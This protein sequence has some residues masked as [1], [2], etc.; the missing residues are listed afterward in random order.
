MAETIVIIPTYNEREN[1][2]SLVLE[3]FRHAPYVNVL[4]VDD[5]SPDGTGVIAD[6]MAKE[7]S[8]VLVMHRAVRKERSADGLREALKDQGV[9][10]VME[11]DADFTHKPSYIPDFLREIKRNDIVIGSRF[12]KGGSDVNRKFSRRCLSR[13][14][15]YFIRAY[16]GLK[17][18]DC[19]SGYRCFKRQVL[20]SIDLDSLVSKGPAVIEELLYI[21]SF[22]GFRIKEI[23]V[24]LQDRKK[25]DSK[26]NFKKLCR[27]LMDII[28]FKRIHMPEAKKKKNREIRGF[29]F[30]LGLGLNIAGCVMFYRERPHFI[31]FTGIGSLGL[32]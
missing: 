16:L 31:W 24:T 27:V 30:S 9:R 3:I 26:L 29:G 2:E 5:N 7:D 23:P 10:Y 25:G 22:K 20:D 18:K 12:I 28:T 21:V 15:N 4:I 17:I 13:F 32:I 19:T 8:R 1:I 6:K 11:M 14:V